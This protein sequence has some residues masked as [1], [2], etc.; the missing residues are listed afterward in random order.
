MKPLATYILEAIGGEYFQFELEDLQQWDI[1]QP[2]DAI[3][4]EE[5]IAIVNTFYKKWPADN[6]DCGTINGYSVMCDYRRSTILFTVFVKGR[7]ANIYR[8]D[9]T[10]KEVVKVIEEIVN[11]LTNTVYSVGPGKD[12]KQLIK[13]MLNKI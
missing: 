8:Q 4:R 5:G 12:A 13:A 9:P 1:W 2:N 6:N 10:N 3:S 11:M 7:G